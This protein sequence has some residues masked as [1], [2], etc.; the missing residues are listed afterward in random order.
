MQTALLQH[1]IDLAR[2]ETVDSFKGSMTAALD[3]I[4][5]SFYGALL[6]GSD[7]PGT[8]VHHRIFDLPDGYFHATTDAALPGVDPVMEHCRTQ[9]IPIA[10]D[11]HTYA[12]SKARWELCAD[13]G[14]G[15]G[16][17]VA[18]HFARDRHF[19]LGFDWGTDADLTAEQHAIGVAAVQ[20]L[21]VFA[22]PAV[23]RIYS[24]LANRALEIDTSL[25]PRE[26]EC[27]SLVSR[28]L[29]DRDIAAVLG[30]SP[31]TVRTHVEAA[32][33]KLNANNRTHAA[34]VA[35]RLGLLVNPPFR[36]F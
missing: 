26:V 30:V 12:D 36:T 1:A 13:F 19:T 27:L 29:T 10:W 31:K 28:G 3:V 32:V 11:R 25:T 2:S 23:H 35:T 33:R 7:A 21:A 14:I 24:R 17:A 18:L 15:R 8:R 5:A 9:S 16:A 6:L 20:M 4:G 34:V 22:E